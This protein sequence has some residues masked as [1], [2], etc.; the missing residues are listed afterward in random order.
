MTESCDNCRFMRVIEGTPT[1]AK[2]ELCCRRAPMPPTY[3]NSA[4]P[5]AQVPSVRWCGEWELKK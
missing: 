2:R 5:F 4:Y 1:L 3:G